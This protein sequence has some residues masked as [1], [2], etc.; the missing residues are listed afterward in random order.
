MPADLHHERWLREWPLLKGRLDDIFGA[1]IA[2]IDANASNVTTGAESEADDFAVWDLQ[3]K[4]FEDESPKFFAW[5]LGEEELVARRIEARLRELS[6][7]FKTAVKR[8]TLVWDE[9]PEAKVCWPPTPL[10]RLQGFPGF[11]VPRVWAQM[12]FA[13]RGGPSR[14]APDKQ[15]PVYARAKTNLNEDD[16]RLIRRDN[17]INAKVAKD[18]G[19][20]ETTIKS[21]KARKSWAHVTDE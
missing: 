16:I 20:S 7:P 8:R 15:Q 1:F 12:R 10:Q 11:A 6:G 4:L 17:R 5:E 14:E 21:I 19:V 3:G 18:Y 2:E 9:K 13:L